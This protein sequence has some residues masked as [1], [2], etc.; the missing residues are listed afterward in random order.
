MKALGFNIKKGELWFCQLEGDRAAPTFLSH[1]RHRFDAEQPRAALA[2]FFK[3]TF[4]EVIDHTRPNRLAYRLSLDASGT[5][6]IA[7]LCYPFGILNLIAHERGTPIFEF[8]TQSFS[9]KALGFSG[10]KLDACDARIAN[11]PEKWGRDVKLA[12]LAAW[13]A[14][15]G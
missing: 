14:L 11:A 5:D 3:Q 7:Y 15:D 6:Q 4:G 1:D 9:K 2:H 10:D 8:V 12:A 13:M